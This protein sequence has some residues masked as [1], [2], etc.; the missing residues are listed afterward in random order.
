MII[1]ITL[2]KDI[3]L[4]SWQ[5]HI[6]LVHLDAYGYILRKGMIAS[7]DLLT[8]QS[9]SDFLFRETTSDLRILLK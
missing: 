2:K 1:N 6:A 4:H 8:N 9:S 7:V 5:I 3:V